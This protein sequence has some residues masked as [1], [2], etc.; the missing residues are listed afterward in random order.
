MERYLRREIRRRLDSWI[1]AVEHDRFIRRYKICKSFRPGLKA[2]ASWDYELELYNISSGDSQI[3]VSRVARIPLQWTG[4]AERQA[5]LRS[6]YLIPDGLILQDDLVI[7]CGANIG[8]FSLICAKAGATVIAFEPDPLEFRALCAN[9]KSEKK[10]YP[11]NKALWNKE[12]RL[13]FYDANDSGDS[14]LIQ[15]N[16]ETSVIE[17]EALRLDCFEFCEFGERPIKLIKLEAEGA[18][19]E[20]LD[21]MQKTLARVEYISAD[22]GPE[23]GVNKN[24]TVAEVANCLYRHGFHLLQFSLERCVGLFGRH[25]FD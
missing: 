9:A 19:P 13:P 21:G 18:E 12:G 24:N 6:Q 14:S 22:M 23:R 20:I 7:D 25:P 2:N 17:V 15:P 1:L 11:Y 16:G 5:Q 8:E 4:I 10:I 3:Y